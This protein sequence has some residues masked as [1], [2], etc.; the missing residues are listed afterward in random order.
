MFPKFIQVG[1]YSGGVYM[2]GPYIWDVNLGAYIWGAYIW[3]H[4]N[5]IL[6]YMQKYFPEKEPLTF[7]YLVFFWFSISKGSTGSCIGSIT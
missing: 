4:I 1:L 3:E 6:W 5:K 7:K 2:G